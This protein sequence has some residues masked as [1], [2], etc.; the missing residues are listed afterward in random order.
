MTVKELFERYSQ[1]IHTVTIC[2][3]IHPVIKSEPIWSGRVKD[4]PA[5]IKDATIFSWRA[6]T[7]DYLSKDHNTDL[8]VVIKSSDFDAKY[9]ESK[10]R[11]SNT[12]ESY[13]YD[14]IKKRATIGKRDIRK[15]AEL[16]GITVDEL[17]EATADFIGKDEATITP[18]DVEH[19]VNS[20]DAYST[21]IP[22]FKYNESK[23]RKSSRKISIRESY[24]DD[25]IIDMWYGDEF[26]TDDYAV[27]CTFYP[28][29]ATYRGNIYRLSDGKIVG[30][31]SCSDSVRISRELG[32][33][34]D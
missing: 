19:F 30:D 17:I 1:P 31:Y 32:Y 15:A 23:S 25:L 9:T 29:D 18:F 33:D 4:I 13:E 10:S 12:R 34:F 2:E 8:I 20:V 14:Q 22:A 28:N 11:T 24:E 26:N 27:S 7:K 6:S 21:A 3:N 16:L 5:N